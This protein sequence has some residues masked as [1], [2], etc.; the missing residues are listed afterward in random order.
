V[1]ESP[2]NILHVVQSFD[3][4]GRSRVIHQLSC[5]VQ[6]DGFRCTIAS[7]SGECGY[8]QND[9]TIVGL[10][11]K[12][13][14]SP[15][16]AARLAAL[17]RRQRICVIHSH[18]RGALP[19]AAAAKALG[20]ARAL[21]HTVHRSDG[22]R[23]SGTRFARRLLLE[24]VDLVA[25]VSE[26]GRRRFAERNELPLNKSVT[27]YNGIEVSRFERRSGADADAMRAE[28]RS[29][30]S[31]VLGTVANL[32]PDK[33]FD[34]LLSGFS[35][36]IRSV[37]GA[38]LLIVG[39][40][41]RKAE[42]TGRAALL[43]LSRSVRFLGRREDVPEILPALDV[44]VLSSHTEGLG[45]SVLE[46]MAAKVPVVASAVGGICEIV[47]DGVTGSLFPYGNAAALRDAVL[48]LA[49]DPALRARRVE[50][51]YRQAQSLSVEKMAK[52]YQEAYRALAAG[53]TSG[54]RAAHAPKPKRRRTPLKVVHVV[55]TLQ[56]GG[57]ELL[58]LEHCLQVGKR[59][60]TQASIFSLRGGDG[61]ELQRRYRTVDARNVSEDGLGK[62]RTVMALAGMLRRERPDIVHTHNF[63]AHLHGSIA[64]KL[65][66][67]PVVVAT[68]HG[69]GGGGLWRSRGLA[70]MVWRLADRVVT[71]SQDARTRFL[72]NYG[73]P[74]ARTRIIWNGVDTERFRP[75][76]GDLE[77]QRNDLLGCTGKPLLG[78][79]ARL[80]SYKG[81]STLLEAFQ[82]VL[83]RAPEAALILAGDGP[84]RGAFEEH[85]ARLGIAPRAHFLGNR[86]DMESVY[87]LLDVFVLPSYTEGI[88]LTVLEAAS[89]AVPVVATRVGGNAEV[90]EDGT[91]GRLVPP[92]DA[93]ALAD[94]VLGVWEDR[95]ASQAMGR[96]GREHVIR[97][98][99]LERMTREYLALYDELCPRR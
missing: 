32:S 75:L 25:A 26:A 70:S 69:Q 46:A 47:H 76:R 64:A 33:D 94:A 23:V 6:R 50:N 99:S 11:K 31:L 49:R 88:P 62:A 73:F 42:I 43:G 24:N 20:G 96:A 89:C 10:G 56:T 34:T 16:T 29:G 95:A 71:V 7:L 8:P 21:L 38:R 98:F 52:E 3:L 63:P 65:A 74:S 90:I 1:S 68:R 5:A 86:K 9:F 92:H 78:T 39:D 13:G 91:T 45:I 17:A 12:E 28:L 97:E 66:G 55:Q 80:V 18:G 35:K 60:D 48:A 44:F 15:A 85:A 53:Q 40:G 36:I 19:Y 67:I 77:Q 54:Y 79:V 82:R 87:P 51:G 22:D 81:I 57:L 14:V 72:R 59:G 93:E 30:A 2:I 84:D 27:I 83:D 4:S 58:V 37:P 41:P 61:L